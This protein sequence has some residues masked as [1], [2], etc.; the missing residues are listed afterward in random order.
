MAGNANSGK[1]QEK[2][3]RDA[4][5]RELAAKG[6]DSFALRKIAA[7]LIDKAMEEADFQSI[8]EIADRLDGK[9]AQ[10]IVGGDEGEELRIITEIRNIIVDPKS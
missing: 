10:A 1:R 3:F 9:P 6:D 7:N 8:R 4:L 5:R 2:L